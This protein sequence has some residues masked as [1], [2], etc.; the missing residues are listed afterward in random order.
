MT[1]QEWSGRLRAWG[2]DFRVAAILLTRVP[3]G[4]HGEIDDAATGRSMRCY[5]LVGAALAAFGAGVYWLAG[6][7]GLPVLVSALL[8]VAAIVIATG[9]LHEDGLADV[10]DGLGG[11]SRERRLEIMRDSRCGAYGV[12][13]LILSIGLRAAA[14]A[15]L[16]SLASVFAALLAAHALSRSALPLIMLTQPLAR[17]DGLAARTGA[18]PAASVAWALGLAGVLAILALGLAGGAMAAVLALMISLG[19]ARLARARLGGYTGDVL[20][21]IQQNVEIA[22]LIF[23]AALLA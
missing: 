13:A 20:G 6:W 14:L 2:D 21:A 17:S 8:V 10:A 23:A 19:V 12:I 1:S 3:M 9:A 11:F 18:P 7:L 22:V 16:P 4:Y 5:P 15:A